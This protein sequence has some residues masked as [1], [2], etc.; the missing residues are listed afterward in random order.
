MSNGLAE[1][2]IFSARVIDNEDTF[3]LGRIRCKPPDWPIQNIL[4]EL[5]ERGILNEDDEDIIEKYKYT[6]DDPFVFMPLLPIFFNFVPKVGEMVWLTYSNPKENWGKKEQFYISVMKSSPFNLFLES[7][8]QS[9][10]IGNRGSN[11][12]PGTEIKSPKSP[13]E[14]SKGREFSYPQR[15]YRNSQV[16]GLFAEPGDNAFY[17]QGSTD[18]ILKTD[19]VLLRAGKTDLTV[20]K[21]TEPNRER[22]FFQLS[23]YRVGNVAKDPE[24][25]ELD[26]IDESPLRK[27]IEYTITNL[28]NSFDAFNGSINIYDVAAKLGL[29]N[30]EFTSETEIPL[31][32][33]PPFYSCNFTAQPLSSIT[34]T[35]NYIIS[36]L[37]NG[38]IE[39][40][41]EPF[42]VAARVINDSFPFFYRPSKSVRD[43]LNITPD[44]SQSPFAITRKFNATNLISRVK[45]VRAILNINGYGL[46]SQKNKF[47]VSTV[48]ERIVIKSSE[49]N[50]IKN[51]VSVMG[52]NK[53]LLLS[54][55]SVIPGK[56]PVNLNVSSSESS[57]IY[58]VS[59]DQIID[60]LIPNTEP[61]VRGEKL[62]E[63]LTLIVKFLTTHCHPFHG[64]PPVP[65]SFSGV[66]ISQI[67]QSFQKYDSDVLN[68]NIRI[69]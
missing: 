23:Y 50:D 48:K 57:T 29:K 66:D 65:A 69:N 36:G 55:Q 25:Q 54:H 14:L 38:R 64:T 9:E 7:S 39:E 30:N 1:K 32:Q 45:F 62:K 22:A 17:G 18:L 12:I 28:E 46:V 52:S 27:L 33:L 20:N 42:F 31:E 49:Y 51:S 10:A 5:K 15:Q 2:I 8:Y 34:D 19:E 67:E 21:V 40:R 60:N 44:F 68:Q 47:G 41:R 16:R 63:F 61:L 24:V 26:K 3:L 56:E 43:V 4:N 6:K 37:N 13:N 11:L 58:G 59:R 35:I 53:I